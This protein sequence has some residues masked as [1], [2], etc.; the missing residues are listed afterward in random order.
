M[1]VNSAPAPMSAATRKEPMTTVTLI[2]DPTET[3]KPRTSS[4]LNCAIATSASGAVASRMCRRLIAVRNT[5]LRSA[6]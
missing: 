3:S 5:S 4:T 1:P 6:A 2:S